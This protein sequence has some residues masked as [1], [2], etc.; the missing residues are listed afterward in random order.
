MKIGIRYKL[1]LGFVLLVSLSFFTQFIIYLA[2]E[3]YGSSAIDTATH[4]KAKDAANEINLYLDSIEE[5]A[6][7]LNKL[8]LKDLSSDKVN[9]STYAD[10]LLSS[11]SNIEQISVLSDGGRELLKIDRTGRLSQDQLSFDLP[12]VEFEQAIDGHSAFTKVF[13]LQ[14]DTIPFI[15][16]YYPLENA[17]N[18]QV[19]KI[20]V[21]LRRLWQVIS[22]IKQYNSGHAYV[23]D[24]SGILIAHPD[25]KL[26]EKRLDF[27]SRPLIKYLMSQSSNI[28]S[29]IQPNS[30]S[31]YI[32]ENNIAITAQGYKNSNPDWI[33]VFENKVA[34]AYSVLHYVR[35]IY[36][37]SYV[38]SMILL[39]IIASL[40]SNNLTKPILKLKDATSL[41]T[42]GKLD[43]RINMKSHDELEDLGKS[44]NNMAENLQDVVQKLEQDKGLLSAERNKMAVA[45]SSITDGIIGVDMERKIIIFN[46]AAERITGYSYDQVLGKPIYD[47]IHFRDAAGEI[48]SEI[49]CPIRTDDY[50]GVVYQNNDIKISAKK[51]SYAHLTVGKIKEGRHVNLGCILA[52][53]DITHEKE[54]EEMKLD[55]V[56]MAAHELRTP[57]TSIRGYLS[58]FQEED[59]NLNQ[60][61]RVFLERISIASDQLVSLVENLLNVTKI[62]KGVMALNKKPVQIMDLIKT[63]T[64]SLKAPAE[65]KRIKV[66]IEDPSAP[67]PMVSVDAFRVSEVI[68]NLLAN[69]IAYTERNGSITVSFEVAD[70]DVITHIQDTGQGIPQEAI[71]HLFTKFYRVSGKLEQGSKGTGLGLYIAKA[72]ID[73]HN[74]KIWVESS[75]NKGSTFSFSLPIENI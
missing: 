37:Y 64:D 5:K 53:E 50:E 30:L 3:S 10:I 28:S 22:N 27:S 42:K 56:S 58:V 14:N 63:I 19:L 70:N 2:V 26:L 21:S 38:G 55:F 57:L 32:N 40:L 59:I 73:M 74:G 25:E 33:I 35:N 41:L 31:N 71:P 67:L 62:E 75:L 4:D 8:Y 36:I 68:T 11:N 15:T 18:G 66:S 60:E 23:L 7:E 9:F 20:L 52:L 13:Y 39:F 1:L 24:E 48:D 47:V 65:Q 34:E 29:K 72:I 51:E 17:D 12:S 6:S 46:K 44:F 45:L 69:A 54:L 49:Y 16:L 61:Q 43:T